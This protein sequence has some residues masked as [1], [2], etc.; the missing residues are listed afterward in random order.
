MIREENGGCLWRKGWMN[1]GGW[2]DWIILSRTRSH[3]LPRIL[4]QA[5]TSPTD[6]LI[7]A[8]SICHAHAH[9]PS[10]PHTLPPSISLSHTHS[11]THSL[12]PSLHPSQFLTHTSSLHLSL[13]LSHSFPPS[14]TLLPSLLLTHSLTWSCE[15]TGEAEHVAKEFENVRKLLDSV[16][17]TVKEKEDGE[18]EE[19]RKMEMRNRW[20]N[21][22]R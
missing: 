3:L 1:G 20:R 13:T 14:L 19:E 5:F 12:T 15:Q 18:E 2:I 17:P 9:A 4:T 11:I 7:H 8:H 21:K 10:L 16:L 6:S 22:K